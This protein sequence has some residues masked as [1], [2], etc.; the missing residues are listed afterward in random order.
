MGGFVG[1]RH[2]YLYLCTITRRRA[3][4]A[5]PSDALFGSVLSLIL[6]FS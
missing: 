3:K 1:P 2:P 4:N 5:K 6:E